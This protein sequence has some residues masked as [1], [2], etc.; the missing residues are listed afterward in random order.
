MSIHVF[1]HASAAAHDPGPGHPE[2]PV[3][4]QAIEA[5]LAEA[6]P[7]GIVR[8]EAPRASRDQLRLA[9]PDRY[10]DHILDNVPS[11][12][13][14]RLDGDTVMSPASGDAA[15]RAAG[16]ACAAVDA[17]FSNAT[18]RAFSLMRPPGHHAEPE[19]AM[20][21]CLFNSIAIAALHARAVHGVQRIAIFDFDVHHGNGTQAIFFDDP[22]TLYLST[23]QMPLYPGTGARSETGSHRTIV[24]RPCPPGTGSKAWRQVVEN[25]ILT[26]IDGFAPGLVM[27]SAGFDAHELDPL[28]QMELV[29][30]DF[31]WAAERSVELAQRHSDGAVVSVLEGGYH[32]PALGRSVIAHLEGLAGGSA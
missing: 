31:R 4:I 16:G 5:A 23:H 27:L 24:N 28:A 19:E 17:V 11:T 9:H 20:G 18:R 8:L 22:D 3:R 32:P 30:D 15:L 1:S 26:A 2:G 21:F 14:A 12:G 29:E 10:I 13:Y 7:R 25:E 6:S